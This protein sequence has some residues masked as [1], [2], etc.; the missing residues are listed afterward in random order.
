MVVKILDFIYNAENFLM[1]I[2]FVLCTIFLLSCL[3][4]HERKKYK[5]MNEQDKKIY[6]R[7][8]KIIFALILSMIL[9]VGAVIYINSRGSVAKI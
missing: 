1:P 4:K 2:C 7:I 5:E 8:L 9:L 3:V 6:R